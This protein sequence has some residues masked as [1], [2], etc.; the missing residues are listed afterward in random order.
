MLQDKSPL[1]I[2]GLLL[3]ASVLPTHA[4]LAPRTLH[5]NALHVSSLFRSSQSRSIPVNFTPKAYSNEPSYLDSASIAT[6]L[7]SVTVANNSLISQHDTSSRLFIDHYFNI[8]CGARSTTSSGYA[9]P[10]FSQFCVLWDSSCPGNL[11][12][13]LSNMLNSWPTGFTDG[14]PFLNGNLVCFGNPF[15]QCMV[16]GV[17]APAASTSSLA[18]LLKLRRSPQCTSIANLCCQYIPCQFEPTVVELYYWPDA[19]ADTSC[20]SIIG[21]SIHPWDYGA[22]KSTFT[23]WKG[24][25]SIETY[26]G[27]TKTSMITT[28]EMSTSSWLVTELIRTAIMADV[29]GLKVKSSYFNPWA[30]DQPCPKTFSGSPQSA[31][32]NSLP[33]GAKIRARSLEPTILTKNRNDTP[34]SVVTLD[35]Q[36]L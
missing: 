1:V 34:I 24:K 20:L 27:C 2:A 21:D 18:E 31:S 12:W 35:G 7:R 14:D 4:Y 33:S 8:S 30:A 11:S 13:A 5:Q 36:T 6:G 28:T 32:N 16:D 17:P 19:D 23:P 25:T 15:C 10:D 29:G 9:F 22:T 26:W 3:L